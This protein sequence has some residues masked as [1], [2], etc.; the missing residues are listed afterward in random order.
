MV[1]NIFDYNRDK[2]KYPKIHPTQKPVNL[3]KHLIS[4]FTDPGDVII[5][6]VA[7][8]GSTLIAANEIDR[9]AYGFEINKKFYAQALKWIEKEKKQRKLFTPNKKRNPQNQQQLI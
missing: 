1:F 4:I 6:P 7:G 3:L 5:D 2:T 8:S 9:E